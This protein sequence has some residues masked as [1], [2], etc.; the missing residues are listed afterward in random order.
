MRL[1]VWVTVMVVATGAALAG[2]TTHF[3]A[4]NESDYK[5]RINGQIFATGFTPERGDEIAVF[6]PSGA[7]IG[8]GV[9]GDMD[10][11]LAEDEFSV[12]T[13][14]DDP[15]TTP[16]DEGAVVGEILTFRYYDGSTNMEYTN[17]AALN[18]NTGEQMNLAWDGQKVLELPFVLPGFD[19]TPSVMADVAVSNTSGTTPGGDTGDS[20][21]TSTGDDTQTS[22]TDRDFDGNGKVD[23]DDVR[24]VLHLILGG[25]SRI[26]VSSETLG[27]ADINGDGVLSTDDIAQFLREM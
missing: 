9:I 3:A 7:V 15:E 1:L 17:V 16:V 18:A 5:W 26:E 24:F 10:R 25:D 12:V 23:V 2:A 4:P 19:L 6:D 14:G 11:S 13:Y 8:T 20:D 22:R 21:T 27:M